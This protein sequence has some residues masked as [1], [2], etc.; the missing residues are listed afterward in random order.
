MSSI[1]IWWGIFFTLHPSAILNYVIKWLY[2]YLL[3][4]GKE[5]MHYEIVMYSYLLNPSAQAGYETRSIF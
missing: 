4:R 5:E 3:Y 1:Y 2:W